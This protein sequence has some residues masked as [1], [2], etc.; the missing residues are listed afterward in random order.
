MSK[1]AA[2][3]RKAATTAETEIKRAKGET[4]VFN[5]KIT[6]IKRGALKKFPKSV[7]HR[8]F[9]GVELF[10]NIKKYEIVAQ[11]LIKE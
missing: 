8:K 9:W 1:R 5:L 3:K 6:P 2:P 11:P 4:N 7:K 10:I